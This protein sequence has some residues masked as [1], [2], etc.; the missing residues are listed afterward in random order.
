MTDHRESSVP[1]RGDGVSWEGD[2]KKS[3]PS[4]SV[5][6]ILTPFFSGFEPLVPFRN[7]DC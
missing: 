3:G 2:H 6:G 1:R 4:H 5:L 7:S